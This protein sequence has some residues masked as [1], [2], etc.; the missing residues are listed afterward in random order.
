MLLECFIQPLWLKYQRNRIDVSSFS[1]LFWFLCPTGDDFIL[2]SLPFSCLEISAKFHYSVITGINSVHN[3]FLGNPIRNYTLSSKTHCSTSSMSKVSTAYFTAISNK[4]GNLC[5]CIHTNLLEFD[6]P[7]S[8]RVQQD[9]H[10]QI[11]MI[12]ERPLYFQP[13]AQASWIR[14]SRL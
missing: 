3:W 9:L 6:F 11:F 5:A 4:I 10:S 14:V 12:C 7:W 1:H 13:G 2:V 8:L